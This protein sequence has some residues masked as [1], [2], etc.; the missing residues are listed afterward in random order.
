MTTKRRVPSESEGGSPTEASAPKIP[1]QSPPE[2]S[3]PCDETPHWPSSNLRTSARVLRKKEERKESE[4]ASDEPQDVPVGVDDCP[5]NPEV[6]S[7]NDGQKPKRAWELW[8]EEDQNLFFVALNECGKNFDAIEIFFQAKSKK[9]KAPST[10][11][12]AGNVYKHKEQIRTFY[13]RTWH[14]ISKYI[15]FPENLKKSSRELYALI[16]Y[17]ELRKK[18]GNSLDK[19][20][21]GKLQEL[22]FKG[23]TS[24]RCKGKFV[25]LRTPACP[26]LKRLNTFENPA[27]GALPGSQGAADGLQ[28]MSVPHK[29]TIELTP[30]NLHD[31][32]YVNRI[33]ASNP[34]ISVTLGV[35]RRLGSV[36]D[37]LEKKFRPVEEKSWINCV[38]ILPP[39]ADTKLPPDPMPDQ[40]LWIIPRP[41]TTLKRPTLAPKEN[42]STSSSI[43]LSHLQS[44]LEPS[45]SSEKLE[46]SASEDQTEP[47]PTDTGFL[48]DSLFQFTD[49][50]RDKILDEWTL[51]TETV[52]SEILNGNTLFKNENFEEGWNMEKAQRISVGELYLMIGSTGLTRSIIQLNYTWKRKS[53]DELA[54]DTSVLQALATLANAELARKQTGKI[55]TVTVGSPLQMKKPQGS[56]ILSPRA[57]DLEGGAVASANPMMVSNGQSS[58]SDAGM[59]EFRRPAVPPVR[60]QHQAF[61]QQIDLLL[62]KYTQRKGRQMSRSKSFLLRQLQAASNRPL[63]PKTIICSADGTVKKLLPEIHSTPRL[64][65]TAVPSQITVTVQQQPVTNINSDH[66]LD[67][68]D[69]DLI[70]QLSIPSPA[71]NMSEN[72]Q[73]EETG[74]NTSFSLSLF[75]ENSRSDLESSRAIMSTPTHLQVDHFLD[76]VLENSNSSLLQTPRRSSPPPSPPG[77]MSEHS[78]LPELSLSSF[79]GSLPTDGGVQESPSKMMLCH[80]EDSMQSTGSEVDRQLS[81]MLTES[82]VD[83]TAKFAKLAS[84]L[85]SND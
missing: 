74:H 18:V 76:S 50:E 37:R 13:Y 82:S 68:Q 15:E 29:V 26:A 43:S 56:I 73:D 67:V 22:V 31:Y 42:A 41:G 36:L 9:G 44:K 81:F 61:R 2:S 6:L 78:W 71:T 7:N 1:R 85:N 65:F 27:A 19:I 24:V 34:R 60:S 33:A 77:G 79:L 64:T 63:Q 46:P 3:D 10:G 57:S 48:N 8:S 5:Q 72:V 17:G 59:A 49:T 4:G 66:L 75:D 11:P 53:E 32:Y 21:S 14:K 80:H 23:Y 55:G 16:N 28:D 52:P 70:P 25:R 39:S 83:F 12:N 20:K 84:A 47:Q 40:E 62:P 45:G 35:D 69:Q 54:E 30:L 38:S 58:N 51:P